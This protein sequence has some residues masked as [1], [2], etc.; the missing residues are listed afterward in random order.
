MLEALPAEIIEQIFLHSLNLNLPRASPFLSRVLSRE[1]TYRTLILLAFWHD[2]P[3]Y[4]SS[5]AIDRM[6]AGPLEYVPLSLDTRERLQEDIF[7]CRWL[8]LERVREQ[9]PTL[10]ILTIRR[11]WIN[12]GIVVDKSQQGEFEQFLDRQIDWPRKFH[13]QGPPMPGPTPDDPYDI[14]GSPIEGSPPYQLKVVP[15][16]SVK[17]DCPNWFGN[18]RFPALNLVKFPDNLLRGR[19][20]GFL[21][22]DVAFL[23]MLRMTSAN[24]ADRHWYKSVR[25][26]TGIT[27]TKVNRK[28]LNE[29]IQ[30]AIR[31]QNLDAMVSLLKIDEF[32]F[33]CSP[34]HC[35]RLPMY[36]I[37]QEHY[38][39]VIRTARDKPQLNLAFFMAL[40]R[41]SAASIPQQSSEVTEWIVDNLAIAK[42]SP[43]ADKEAHGRFANWLSSWQMRLPEHI[44]S[45]H[46]RNVGE[47][48]TFGALDNGIEGDRFFQEVLS[49]DH[50]PYP[51]WLVESSFSF[52][53][54][55]IKESGRSLPS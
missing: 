12:A 33:R 52:G 32:T 21:P 15:M 34:E 27:P 9:V 53:D 30:K 39:T 11:H 26:S 16:V 6:M 40:Y 3:G 25:W 50:E 48:F 8:T 31:T 41:A 2:P 35:R 55:W 1:H 47:F 29:G 28:A 23:E 19:S 22:E 43:N 14:P 17:I 4:P 24:W 45:L 13:G 37:P 36:T 20:N 46:G 42:Y 38:L 49:P 44:D 7:K 10:Q 51:N 18:F 5:L 54:Y